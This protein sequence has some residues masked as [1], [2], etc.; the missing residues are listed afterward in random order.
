MVDDNEYME[1]DEREKKQ[2]PIESTEIS[3]KYEVIGT[4][5]DS[6]VI[7]VNSSSDLINGTFSIL[8]NE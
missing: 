1:E 5:L 6:K 3:K 8:W 2:R 4:I 7:S